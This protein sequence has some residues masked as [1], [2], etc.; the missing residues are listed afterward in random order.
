MCISLGMADRR[1]W[2]EIMEDSRD[3]MSILPAPPLKPYVSTAPPIT[4]SEF[5]NS[6]VGVPGLVRQ[7]TVADVQ[8]H[9]PVSAEFKDG[10]F[11]SLDIH[12]ISRKRFD[13]EEDE[14]LT[15][16]FSLDRLV[17]LFLKSKKK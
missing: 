10:F 14:Q 1:T 13:I 6:R 3:S 16:F 4:P 11:S 8:R 12:K 7:M 9:R 2:A 17:S 15:L 5:E